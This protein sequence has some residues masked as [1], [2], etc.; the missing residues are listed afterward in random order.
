MAKRDYN[1]LT[2]AD[3]NN[4]NLVWTPLIVSIQGVRHSAYGPDMRE[5]IARGFE[6][7]GG[8]D[9]SAYCLD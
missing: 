7:T 1:R 3:P 8:T 4:L 2:T 9:Q 6:S 5:H